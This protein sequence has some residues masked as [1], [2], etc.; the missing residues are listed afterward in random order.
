MAVLGVEDRRLL[1]RETEEL[2][3]EIGEA[4]Q[5]RGG[6]YIAGMAQPC[7]AFARRQQL[8]L[9]QGADRFH[10]AH[11]IVPV[12]GHAGRARQMRGHADD[13]DV[14]IADPARFIHRRA[15]PRPVPANC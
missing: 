11:E 8:G 5:R 7:G 4:V 15:V 14:A 10:A 6:R 13:R 1:G 2:G 9:G 12:R 3:L